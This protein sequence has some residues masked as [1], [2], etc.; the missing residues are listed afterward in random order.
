MDYTGRIHVRKKGHIHNKDT[1][2]RRAC[3]ESLEYIAYSVTG[4][5]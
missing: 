1:V 5:A 4:V 2:M 3:W